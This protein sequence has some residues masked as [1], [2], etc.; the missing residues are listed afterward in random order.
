MSRAQFRGTSGISGRAHLS[1][2]DDAATASLNGTVD[3]PVHLMQANSRRNAMTRISGRITLGIL[4]ASG[5]F[6]LSA[7][8]ALA[9]SNAKPPST[10]TT[11]GGGTM[12]LGDKAPSGSLE[13][14]KGDWRGSELVG[15]TVY[16]E[17][18][19]SV[20]TISDL[21]VGSDG[22][23]SNAILSVGGFLG[24]GSKL[25][26][27]PFKNLKF[28]PSQSNP[29]S[30]SKEANAS[31]APAAAGSANPQTA[32][33]TTGAAPGAPG[34]TGAAPGAPGS[35]DAAGS[36]GGTPATA[37]GGAPVHGAGAAGTAAAPATS[38][39]QDFS[40]VLP[41]AT[42]DTLTSDPTFTFSD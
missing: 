8:A 7:T 6:A 29:A 27:V 14:T 16:N 11:S 34:S 19:N 35:T 21:L 38:G 26:E 23:V 30:G 39:N 17:Q 12:A 5:F 3:Q 4:V 42:K 31:S 24:V 25:V 28:V 13:K 2:F 9:Q 1:N 40:L 10:S 22:S 33:G 18:G 15:A 36:T 32:P 20:G 41:G 37:M